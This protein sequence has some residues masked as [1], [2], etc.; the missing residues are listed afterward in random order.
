M[1]HVETWVISTTRVIEATNRSSIVRQ[2]ICPDEVE[3]V[4]ELP[5]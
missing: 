1:V 5:F 2:A 3:V 4:L